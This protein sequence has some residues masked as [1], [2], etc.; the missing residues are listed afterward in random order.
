[1]LSKIIRTAHGNP[2][3]RV[4]YR[5]VY[6]ADL[7]RPL[8]RGHKLTKPQQTVLTSTTAWDVSV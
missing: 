2:V 7:T 6:V 4:A 5:Y 3:F 1:M 8:P